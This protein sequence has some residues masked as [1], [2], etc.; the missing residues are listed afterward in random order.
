MKKNTIDA[1]LSANPRGRQI[2]SVSP[3]D[4]IETAAQLM[5]RAKVGLV[6][7]LEGKALVGVLSERDIVRKWICGKVYPQ[8]V[9]VQDLMTKD[10][11]VVTYKDTVF[12]CYLRFVA[13]NCRHLPVVDP[14]GQVLGVLSMR[15]IT[16]FVVNALSEQVPMDV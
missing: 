8:S 3:T 6:V 5:S 13:R 1:L 7:V 2:V 10:V 11:E 16:G 14:F 9:L 15:D 12:D 4:S